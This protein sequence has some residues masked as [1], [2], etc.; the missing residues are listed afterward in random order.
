[1]SAISA[2]SDRLNL[3]RN[4][5][6]PPAYL[7]T[8]NV[9]DCN[10]N[11]TCAAGGFSIYVYRYMNEQG[12]PQEGCNNYQAKDQ[13]CTPFNQCG[14]FPAPK[15]DSE[16]I[17]NYQKFFISEYGRI[18]GREQMMQEI[19]HAG[20]ISCSIRA[21]EALEEW[22]LPEAT[23]IFTEKYSPVETRLLLNHAISVGG[24][25]VDSNGTEYWLVRNSWGEWWGDYGWY[26]TPTSAAFNGEGNKYNLG[27]ED[28]CS[29]GDVVVPN[30]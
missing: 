13:E 27:V 5:A 28:S 17:T 14:T 22:L 11:G 29:W 16:V 6:W 10:G 4:N 19:F 30:Y 20:P 3:A 2:S 15:A 1:M 25:G 23:G 8:Q 18:S 9:I 24:W 21:T 7:S 26:K 12:V